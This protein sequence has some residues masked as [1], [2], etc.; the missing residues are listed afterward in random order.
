MCFLTGF[1]KKQLNTW[2]ANKRARDMKHKPTLL[3]LKTAK[4]DDPPATPSLEPKFAS[5]S[6]PTNSMMAFPGSMEPRFFKTRLVTPTETQSTTNL[7]SFKE[8]SADA[9]NRVSKVKIK[10][11]AST[12]KKTQSEPKQPTLSQAIRLSQIQDQ[13]EAEWVTMEKL[14]KK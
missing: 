3:L 5:H 8:N 1:T 13:M 11:D 6:I 7:F 4:A 10:G 9:S 14:L 2:F 12:K